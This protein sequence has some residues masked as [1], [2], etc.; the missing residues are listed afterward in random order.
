MSPGRMTPIPYCRVTEEI[1]IGKINASHQ[2]CA[3]RS[4]KWATTIHV[5][6]DLASF[7]DIVIWSFDVLG[8]IEAC[9]S[10]AML[11]RADDNDF[12]WPGVISDILNQSRNRLVERLISD[13]VWLI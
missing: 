10:I 6:E 12:R 3:A 8:I 11:I 4:A 7:E 2:T 1:D 9:I 13:G 5:L